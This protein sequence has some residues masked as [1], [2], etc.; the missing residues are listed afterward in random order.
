MKPDN[1]PPMP[2]HLG[3]LLSLAVIAAVS[4]QTCSREAV[5]EVEDV[6]DAERE[7]S[8][9]A[10]NPEELADDGAGHRLFED[11]R[12]TREVAKSVSSSSV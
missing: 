10:R 6:Q 4:I 12:I 11:H 5:A 8:T 7:P 3:L 9:V 2:E 1:G